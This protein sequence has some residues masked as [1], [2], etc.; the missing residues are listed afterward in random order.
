MII[1]FEAKRLFQNKSGLGNY[2]RNTVNHLAKYY[3]EHQY[4]LY[5]PRLSDLYTLPDHVMAKVPR[6]AFY[7]RFRVI[8]RL[9]GQKNQ[10][11]HDHLQIFHGLSHI[12]PFGL[13]KQ[14]MAKVVTIHDLIFLRFPQ[15]YARLDRM[16]YRFQTVTSCNRA[17]KILAISHQT[18]ADLVN[19][20]K[21]DERKIVVIHQSCD[22]RFYV[23][24]DPAL[25]QA[26]KEKYNLPDQFLLC[27][28]TIESRKNQLEIL[29]AV[30]SEQLDIP[31]V[32]LGKATEYKR[33]L[34]DYILEHDLRKQLIFLH[35][36]DFDELHSIYQLATIMVYPSLFEGFGL[37]VLEAQASGC[38]VITSNLSSM[39]EA[40][41]EGAVYIDPTQCCEL[42]KA[43]R[44]LLEDEPFRNEIIGKGRAN[45][46]LFRD[47]VVAEK[48]MQL[49]L[50]LV[51]ELG[52][53]K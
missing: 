28:G 12:L 34:D 29:R 18:K 31:I 1:G 20:L 48:L 4:L 52:G 14:G 43:I 2:S 38:P 39:P 51:E 13:R 16:F 49:Y 36:T 45:A 8:W 33:K 21:I 7:K 35:H 5:A 11:N 46:A 42:G 23:P 37:P 19:L 30:V 15:F 44:H 26:V 9:Y 6:S 10:V 25:L 3:P 22:N 27:V 17:T 24:A 50:S 53:E 40:G 47:Q 32:I 41:G